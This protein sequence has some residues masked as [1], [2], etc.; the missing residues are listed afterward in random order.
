MLFC[1]IIPISAHAA[2]DKAAKYFNIKV[3]HIPVDPQSRQ[4]NL[5]KVKRAM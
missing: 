4:V 2:F 1:R 3:H 5:K